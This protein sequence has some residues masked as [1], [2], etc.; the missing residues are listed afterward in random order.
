MFNKIFLSTKQPHR[1][2][3]KEITEKLSVVFDHHSQNNKAIDESVISLTLNAMVV[4][5]E[6]DFEFEMTATAI[7]KN[8]S[9]E[10]IDLEVSFENKELFRSILIEN[11]GL[12][13][14]DYDTHDKYFNLYFK[15]CENDMKNLAK[16]HFIAHHMNYGIDMHIP[17][18]LKEATLI[19]DKLITSFESKYSKDSFLMITDT[20]NNKEIVNLSCFK[21][22]C[23]ERGLAESVL[24]ERL[25]DLATT[26][27]YINRR[28]IVENS[29][30]Q[31]KENLGLSE[32]NKSKRTLNKR[33]S[34]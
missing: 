5:T 11:Y 4:D 18:K 29:K 27:F 1:I 28:E 24:K 10:W 7:C 14:Y 34:I 25:S 31:N 21:K 2:E 32:T 19:D 20:E 3:S 22:L 17:V 23:N 8:D 9:D 30:C 15:A 6:N 13:D 12:N 33:R 26:N 16:F